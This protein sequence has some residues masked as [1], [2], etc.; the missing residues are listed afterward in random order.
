MSMISAICAEADLQIVEKA[1]AKAKRKAR[2]VFVTDE[3]SKVIIILNDLLQE[4][5][6]KICE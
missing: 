3:Y 2:E 5:R 1:V 4:C 6:D